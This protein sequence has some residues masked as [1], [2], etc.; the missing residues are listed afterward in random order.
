MRLMTNR[1][2]AFLEVADEE[3]QQAVIAHLTG[4]DLGIT[5]EAA[6]EQR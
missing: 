5:V 4:L 6:W 1:R 3:T 2:Y